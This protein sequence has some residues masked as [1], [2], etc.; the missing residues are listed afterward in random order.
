MILGLAVINFCFLFLLDYAMLSSSSTRSSSLKY[1]S[2]FVTLTLWLRFM[3][4]GGSWL[5]VIQ[6][7]TLINL[8]SHHFQPFCS[9][10]ENVLNPLSANPTKW[11]NTLKQFVGKLT[12]NCLSVIHHFVKDCNHILI[13]R[14]T[15]VIAWVTE[16]GPGGKINEDFCFK[17]L[18]NL[19]N[20]VSY[21]HYKELL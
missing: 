12:T 1:K 5:P 16:L 18:Y 14:L 13:W 15:L 3:T 8:S 9:K 17:P 20:S 11:P 4:V 2:F 19:H 7:S 10:D 21:F 6:T